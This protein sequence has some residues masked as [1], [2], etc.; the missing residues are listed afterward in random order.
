[1]E[2]V[3][4]TPSEDNRIEEWGPRQVIK[5]LENKKA[6]LYLED[7]D[8]GAFSDLRLAGREFLSLTVDK[9]MKCGLQLGPALRIAQLI[10]QLQ[11][12]E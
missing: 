4:I 7:K 3:Q 1:M 12:S 10:E 5:F 8:I 9:L 2:D 6:E 11:G